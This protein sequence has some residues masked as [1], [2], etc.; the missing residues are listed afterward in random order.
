MTL[1]RFESL[2]REQNIKATFFHCRARSE[3]E[4]Y[5][6]LIM[7]LLRAG[8]RAANHS[9]SH[10]LSFRSLPPDEMRREVWDA[11]GLFPNYQILRPRVFGP[12]DTRQVRSLPICLMTPA[13]NMMAQLMPGPYGPVFRWM[14]RRLHA[15]EA[16]ARLHNS[17]T[18]VPADERRCFVV[19][20]HARTKRF[21]TLPSA[22]SITGAPA[23]P[24]RRMHAAWLRIFPHLLEPYW[25][26]RALPFVFSTRLICRFSQVPYPLF[27]QSS[28]FNMPVEQRF[29]LR[30]AGF[31]RP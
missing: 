20:A 10:N 21:F 14:D 15:V 8:H 1:P 18:Q 22:T 17:Q 3:G 23:I 24:G 28:F 30:H 9:W 4:N 13:T 26:N 25:W 2:F 7:R 5:R 19:P 31:C 27:R 12:P 29:R 11:H 16:P 6:A